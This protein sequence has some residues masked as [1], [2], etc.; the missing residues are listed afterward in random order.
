MSIEPLNTIAIQQFIQLVK[1]ADAA[2]QRDIRMDINAAKNLAFVLGITMSRL[3]G[4]LEK[5]IVDQ[6]AKNNT[7]D[8]Q[9]KIDGSSWS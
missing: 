5:L 3:Q 1:S 7:S 9:I 4:N 6:L 2:G 8:V